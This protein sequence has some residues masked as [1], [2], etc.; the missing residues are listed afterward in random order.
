MFLQI[1][2]LFGI[3][4]TLIIAT[5]LSL[6]LAI[7]MGEYFRVGAFSSVMRTAVVD[8]TRRISGSP[9]AASN[10]NALDRR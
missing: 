9:L 7:L 6:A 8:R 2:P 5:V 3:L 10:W 4:G 1:F